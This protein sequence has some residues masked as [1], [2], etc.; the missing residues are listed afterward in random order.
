MKL[1]FGVVLSFA[2]ALAFWIYLTHRAGDSSASTTMSTSVPQP[3]L[4]IGAPAPHGSSDEEV[5]APVMSMPA[6]EEAGTIS[7][8]ASSDRSAEK[9]HEAI[10]ALR[11]EVTLLR[12][13]VS[14][15]Q[16][17]I[18]APQRVATVVAPGRADDPAR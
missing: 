6:D 15:L 3:A 8:V 11:E 4:G 2:A 10:A 9:Q 12:A 13:E 1:A 17:W 7:A 16:R 5:E 14:A 18:H